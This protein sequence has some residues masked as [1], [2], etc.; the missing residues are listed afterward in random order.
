MDLN[1]TPRHYLPPVE[2]FAWTRF[3]GFGA[4][5]GAALADCGTLH[6][7]AALQMPNIVPP[8]ISATAPCPLHDA[9]SLFVL[10]P[11]LAHEAPLT[12]AY[13]RTICHVI[14]PTEKPAATQI[15]LTGFP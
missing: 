1:V 10:R 5:G 4:N 9:G 7:L 6:P 13:G 3:P 2:F 11:L 15:W 14:E 8:P 12:M